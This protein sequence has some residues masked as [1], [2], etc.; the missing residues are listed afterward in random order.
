MIQGMY[1]GENKNIEFKREIPKNHGKFLK[2]VIAFANSSGGKVIIG[3]EDETGI[4]R[5]I[6][7]QSPF[8][9]SD[10]ISTMIPDACAPQIA[11]AISVS[12]IEDKTIYRFLFL[13]IG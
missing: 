5:G 6:G 3:I 12:T 13:M 7:E 9:L 8:K 10:T 11:S 2:D 1:F 4:V